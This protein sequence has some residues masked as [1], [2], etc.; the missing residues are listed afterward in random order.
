MQNL[1]SSF[2]GGLVRKL[3]QQSFL[4]QILGSARTHLSSELSSSAL[5]AEFFLI[6]FL[7]KKKKKS[8]KKH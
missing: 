5:W 7:Q 4:G 6:N 2:E 1:V 3:V 8:P